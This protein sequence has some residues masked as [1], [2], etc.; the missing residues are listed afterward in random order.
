MN[1][2]H[3]L[4][5]V[6]ARDWVTIL[7]L[8]IGTTLLIVLS[9]WLRHKLYW[10]EEFSRKLVHIFVGVLMF[11]SPIMLESSRPLVIIA[12]FFLI[13]NFVAVKKGWLKGMHG[14]RETYGTVYYPLSF[15]ILVLLCWENYKIILIAS[16]MILAIGDAL[17]AIVGE[18]IKKPHQYI[19]V[20]EQKS[21]EGSITMFFVS[22]LITA[23]VLNYYPFNSV[24]AFDSTISAVWIS[25]MTGIIAAAAEALSSKGSDNL[26]VPIFVAIFLYFM[27]HHS[28]QGNVQLTFGII[29]AAIVASI[30]LKAQFLDKSGAVATFLLAAVIFG[31]GGCKWILP[32]LLFFVLSS[33]LSKLG[34]EEK[35]GYD[36]MF[37][38]GSKRDYAQVMANGGVAA[39]VMICYM[40]YQKPILY[41]FY[42]ASIA[43]AMADTWA[44]EIGTLSK[45]QPRLFSTFKK[46]APGTSGGVTFA[47]LI[48]AILGAFLIALCAWQFLDNPA[49][50]DIPIILFGI[51]ISG[52]LASLFDSL[53]G[54]TIQVQYQCPICHK[55]TE[56]KIHCEGVLAQ[57][58]S[59]F[60]WMNN[61][62]VNFLNTLSA[63][64]FIYILL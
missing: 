13:F 57:P 60:R 15:L 51:T 2:S 33:L 35:I 5:P 52:F 21:F 56:K 22:T 1:L 31:S 41:I 7:I 53:L 36:T 24:F 40:F 30:S 59:G 9:E 4:Q 46:V 3:V 23:L 6:P 44:T 17:A 26:T 63:L 32:I 50:N 54:A 42:L 29:L 39:G 45:Q 14:E 16:M 47:G 18:S 38:K 55:T 11:F 34:S 37:E 64:L 28:T 20:R 43:A 19:L 25:V 10:S 12:L 62:M 49:T 48:G 58:V 27:L 61:D 8:F